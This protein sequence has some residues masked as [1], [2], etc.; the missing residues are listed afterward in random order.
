LAGN[1]TLPKPTDER[2]DVFFSGLAVSRDST[3]VIGD[4]NQ[5]SLW[6]IDAGTGRLAKTIR[7][8][9]APRDVAVGAGGVWVTSQ[10]ADRLLRIDPASGRITADVPTGRG[11]AGGAARAGVRLGGKP[12]RHPP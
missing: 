12:I 11:A 4:P 2:A 9:Y 3:W 6:R 5:P 7:W 1:V 8:P 10:L